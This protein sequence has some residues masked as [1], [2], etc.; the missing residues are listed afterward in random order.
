MSQTRLIVIDA[1]PLAYRSYHAP[2][3]C[4][5]QTSTGGLSGAFFGFLR[6]YLQ[7]RTRFHGSPCVFCF[8][9]GRSW[10]NEMFAGYKTHGEED[11]PS[12]F[13][14]QLNDARKFLVALGVPVFMEPMLEADDLIGVLASEWVA[15]FKDHTAIIVS[16]DRDFWQL[17]SENIMLYDDRAKTFYG[18]DEVEKKTGVP[19]HHYLNY[20]CLIG[21]TADKIPG[22]PG[23]GPV[24]AARICHA[25]AMFLIGTDLDLLLRNS[26]LM[27][28]PIT[29]MQL[30]A[31]IAVRQRL[32]ADT[33]HMFATLK[34]P[35]LPHTC[36]TSVAQALLDQ[37]E[38]KSLNL[39]DFI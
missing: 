32:H 25:P 21:D 13:L 6:S 15:N 5:L 14:T 31:K 7:L 20:K 16:S 8:D 19:L 37:Y 11:K 9:S 2:G 17:V 28:L 35:M 23:Y 34:R 38:C 18:P 22:V 3:T 39:R 33:L 10:R 29:V 30:H 4:N 26:L 24:K 1:H 27:T 36:N 12:A